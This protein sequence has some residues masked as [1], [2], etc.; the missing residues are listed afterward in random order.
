M[1]YALLAAPAL[2]VLTVAA[3]SA[4]QP[5]RAPE[6]REDDPAAL[7]RRAEQR[8][9]EL[10]AE[11][12][13][14]AKSAGTLLG[15]LR[16][17]EI[18]REIQAEAL[19]KAEAER[20]AITAQRD[21]AAARVAAL[22]AERVASTEG[23]AERLVAI[24]TRGRGGYVR[25]LLQADDLRALGRM[26]R[27][28]AAVAQL[29]RL[30][31][32]QHRRTLQAERAA[33]AELEAQRTALAAAEAAAREARARLDRAVRAHRRRLDDID[34]QRDLAARYIG[35]LQQAAV[36]LQR[37]VAGLDS[38][39]P[40]TLPLAPFRGTLPWPVNGRVVARFGPTSGR[41]GAPAMIRNGIE[42][43]A[44]AGAPVHAVHGGTVSFAAPF[45]GYGVLVIL[46]HGDDE[47]T[48][49]GHLREAA[50]EMGQRLARGAI[51][52]YAGRNPSGDEVVYFEVRVDGRPVDP[53]QWLGA[54]RR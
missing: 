13:R 18:Q 51:V 16:A 12:D 53:V 4:Q 1:R 26:T 15:E 49:Y 33:V 14:L 31:I 20:A 19:K 30:R 8:I 10:Q 28:V 27:G 46:D 34:R 29:D 42:I 39:A 52:G 23:V 5:A 43:E 25:M 24:Y 17:L 11:A 48:L 38:T 54:A 9:A 21:R 44:D 35:E 37:H 36:S 2:L 41:G 6:A 3:L 32:E 45:V 50:V 40:P 7:V 22:E 47:F